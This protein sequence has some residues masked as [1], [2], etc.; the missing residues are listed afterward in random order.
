MPQYTFKKQ[1][2]IVLATMA[3][4]NFIRRHPSRWDPEFNA[5]DADESSF[6]PS[7]DAHPAA[8]NDIEGDCMMLLEQN[9]CLQYEISLPKKYTMRAGDRKAKY[10][11]LLDWMF[12]RVAACWKNI[13]PTF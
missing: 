12:S 2:S 5:C 13:Y 6:I 11:M 7:E 10:M 3:L 4:H 9:I 1:R 8:E